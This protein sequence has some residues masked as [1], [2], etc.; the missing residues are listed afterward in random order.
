M[1]KA[2]KSKAVNPKH[3]TQVVI[4]DD[5]FHDERNALLIDE[6]SNRL[7]LAEMEHGEI[8]RHGVTLVP[9]AKA[10]PD[11]FRE[12]SVREAMAWYGKYAELANGANGDIWP[13]ARLAAEKLALVE[14]AFSNP[15]ANHVF[16]AQAKAML[17][18]PGDKKRQEKEFKRMLV[19]EIA[20]MAVN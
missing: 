5:H 20:S 8:V 15:F 14:L 10:K 3:I 13:V 17:S 6:R 9:I 1:K 12:V 11:E 2:V 4:L 18:F 19:C 7:F 16:M